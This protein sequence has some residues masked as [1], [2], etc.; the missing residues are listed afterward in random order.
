MKKR[1]NWCESD[2]AYRSYHDDE[3]G[4]PV[5]DDQVLFEFLILEWA[6]AGLSWKTILNKRAWYREVFYN[7]DAQVCATLSDEYLQEALKNPA[8][9]RNKLKVR[10]VR[11]NAKVFLAIQSEFWSFSAYLR[12]RVDNVPVINNRKDL[13]EVP[14]STPLSDKISKDL[15]KRGMSFVWTTIVY[16][17]LQ[18]VGVIDDH[19]KDCRKRKTL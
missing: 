2:D 19:V 9:I 4:V 8:I 1:C 3:R 18:A 13:T 6:Q 10:S 16:A 5:Y 14:A 12:E 15:K 11:K 17:Y 7:F